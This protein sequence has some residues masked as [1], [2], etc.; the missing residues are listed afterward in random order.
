VSR[1]YTLAAPWQATVRMWSLPVEAG[2][3]VV[4]VMNEDA[5]RR[6]QDRRTDR[7]HAV[8]RPG[9]DTGA[10]MGKSRGSGSVKRQCRQAILR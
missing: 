7:G 10:V 1:A 4:V 2:I 3:S 8:A 6:S 5:M 9:M